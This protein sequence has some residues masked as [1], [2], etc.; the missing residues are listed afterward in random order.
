MSF[1]RELAVPYSYNVLS[2][3]NYSQTKSLYTCSHPQ[4]VYYNAHHLFNDPAYEC[5]LEPL[6]TR[7]FVGGGVCFGADSPNILRSGVF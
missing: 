1:N 3:I 7:V 5:V 2:L 4:L 6:I